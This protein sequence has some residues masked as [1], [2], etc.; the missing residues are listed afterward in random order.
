MHS[1]T[2]EERLERRQRRQRRLGHH[3]VPTEVPLG[4]K[5]VAILMVLQGVLGGIGVLDSLLTRAADFREALLFCW[6]PPLH[7]LLGIALYRGSALA[8]QLVTWVQAAFFAWVLWQAVQ[9]Y[10]DHGSSDTAGV[11]YIIGAFIGLAVYGGP[12]LYLLLAR[13]NLRAYLEGRKNT[14]R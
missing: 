4:I 13:K 1:I 3:L 2:N 8:L 10:P 9:A 6:V 12:L 14:A 11:E 5:V 7:L